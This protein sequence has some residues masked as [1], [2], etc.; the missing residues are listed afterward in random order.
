MAS[1]VSE[2]WSL[3][4][5]TGTQ[6]DLNAAAAANHGNKVILLI[7]AQPF[8]QL[9]KHVSNSPENVNEQSPAASTPPGKSG[10]PGRCIREKA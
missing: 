6:A 8:S 4:T 5:P 10:V 1:V 7:F 9:L 3:H 2:G